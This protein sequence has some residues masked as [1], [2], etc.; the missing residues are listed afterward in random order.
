MSY[1]NDFVTPITEFWEEIY[2]YTNPYTIGE[3]VKFSFEDAKKNDVVFLGFLDAR[4]SESDNFKDM[5]L[6]EIRK[7]FYKLHVLDWNFSLIDIGNI[8]SGETLHDS[9]IAL[10]VVLKELKNLEV[11]V[12]VFGGSNLINHTVYQVLNDEKFLHFTQISPFIGLDDFNHKLTSSNFLTQILLEQPCK[13]IQYTSIA[14][15]NFLNPQIYKDVLG[16]LN[17]ESMRLGELNESISEI[18]PLIRTSDFINFDLNVMEYRG[19]VFQNNPQPNGISA[20]QACTILRYCGAS[21]Y[22]QFIHF[23]NYLYESNEKVSSKLIAQLIWHFIDGQQVCLN[24]KDFLEQK[25]KYTM[26]LE[27]EELIFYKEK[28][29]N[30][31]WMQCNM[32]EETPQNYLIP[33][34]EKEYQQ[35]VNGEIPEKYWKTFKK[36]L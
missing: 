6:N 35:A 14:N 18:E 21:E 27:N 12:I 30:R 29:S 17:F 10:E 7:Q 25:V 4:E 36:F 9:L 1:I 28:I 26:L 19:E 23:S 13:L 31:W 16:A 15:Q 22:N 24:I 20:Y 34:S 11:K 5:N 8:H 2:S 33:C 32:N 3:N